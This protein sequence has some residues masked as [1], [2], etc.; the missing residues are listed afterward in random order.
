MIRLLIVVLVIASVDHQAI[1]R[2]IVAVEGNTVGSDFKDS[3]M[4]RCSMSDAK[5]I[6]DR[7][8]LY[9]DDLATNA[10]GA[11]MSF[12]EKVDKAASILAALR[13]FIRTSRSQNPNLGEEDMIL[14]G[15][16]EDNIDEGEWL[17]GGKLTSKVVLRFEIDLAEQF[18]AHYARYYAIGDDEKLGLANFRY[19]WAK[20][21]YS[22]LSCLR[23]PEIDR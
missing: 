11:G 18:S 4:G 22:G 9:L 21:I 1:G 19:D 3:T 16:V 12:V 23:I 17:P 5:S 15:S 6:R 14:L 2:D 10:C 20:K 7:I 8:N 13:N